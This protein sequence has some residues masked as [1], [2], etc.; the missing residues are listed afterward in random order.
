MPRTPLTLALSL[1]ALVGAADEVRLES[2]GAIRGEVI[3]DGDLPRSVVAV[4]SPWGRVH[5]PRTDVASVTPQSPAHAEYRRRAPTVSDTADSQMALALWCRDRGL[6]DELRVHAARVLELDPEHEQARQLLGYRQVN[7]QWMTRDDLLARRGLV[8]HDGEYRT[9]QEIELVK[10]AEAVEAATREWKRKL[11]DLRE[12]LGS[13][14][15]EVARNAAEALTELTDPLALGPLIE[16]L[17]DERDPRAKP[18]LIRAVGQYNNG[19][20]LGALVRVALE[21]PDPEARAVSLEQLATSARP[22]LAAPFVGAL[23]SSDNVAIN[24]AADALLA[25]GADDAAGPLVEA[26]VS[27]HRFRVGNDSGGD[28]YSMNTGAGTHSFG[29]N[30]PKVIKR[31]MKNPSVLNALVELTG[32]NFSYDQHAWMAWLASRQR[33]V[34]IDLRRDS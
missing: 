8:R 4:E 17:Y 34:E 2:G 13:P 16:L 29:G 26:L 24:R 9:R 19:A 30:S 6:G 15:A 18:V 27:T 10:Q 21:D 11:G 23:G 31:Q 22:G 12:E 1:L 5:L 3:R 25:L 28:T 33:E 14:R 20:A 32:V 7:G